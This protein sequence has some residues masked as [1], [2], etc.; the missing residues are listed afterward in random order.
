MQN[1]VNIGG[2]TISGKTPK[3]ET[4]AEHIAI[5]TKAK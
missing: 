5:V 1:Q 2:N 4:V 3:G